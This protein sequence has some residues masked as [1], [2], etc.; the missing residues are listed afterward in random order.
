LAFTTSTDSLIG[1]AGDDIVTASAG[2]VAAA[3]TVIDTSITDSDTLTI[4]HS[5]APGAFTSTNIET[6]DITVNNLGAITVDAANMTGATGGLTVTRGDVVVGG[7]TLTGN[8]A[9]RVDNADSSALG[10]ITA[11][12]ATTTVDINSAAADKAGHVV[13]ANSASGNVSV[14]GAATINASASTGTVSIDAVTNTTAAETGKAS[15]IN[16]A[17]AG[18]VTSH[19]DLTGSVTINAAKATTVTINDAQGGATVNAATTHTADST[20]TVVDVDASGATITVGTGVDDTTTT[21]NI[22]LDVT[23]DGTTATTDAATISGAGHIEL[24]IDGANDGNVDVITLSGN[25][26]SVIYDLA[27]PSSGTAASFTKSGTHSVEIMGDIS[28]FTAI[29]ITD[30]D[31]I[32]IIAGTAAAFNGSNFSGVGKIDLGIDNSNNALTLISGSNLEVTT[33]TQTTGLDIDFSAAGGGDVTITAGDVTTGSTVGTVTVNALNA[34]AAAATTVGTV[35]L[36]AAESNL[37]ATSTVLA[38]KQN[39]VITGDEDV[40][41][42]AVTADSV[43]AANSTGVI[44]MTAAGN[45]D[46]IASGSGNDAITLNDTGSAAATV[47]TG[48]GNDTITITAAA[49]TTTIDGGDGNETFNADEVDQIVMVGGAGNDNFATAVALGG[50]IVGGDGADTITIDGA[51]ALT[52]A[53]TFAFSSIEELDITAANG[54]VDITGAQLAGN[55]T[56]IIDGDAAAD[57]FNVNTG[58][59]AAAAKSADLSN[60]T[61]KS[62]A[63]A[64]I[65]VTGNVGVDTIT[66]GVQSETFTQTISG[67]TI[68]G[69]GG[70]GVDVYQTVTSLSDVLGGATGTSAGTIVNL[71]TTAV[72]ASSIGSNTGTTAYISGNLTSV[73]AGSASFIYT[74]NATTNSGALDTVSGIENVTGSA[75]IDYVVG[76]S[77]NNTIST[78]AGIDYVEGGDGNDTIN[79]GD[80]VDVLAGGNGDD[81]FTITALSDLTDGSNAVEDTIN[82]GN[83]TGDTIAFNGGVTLAAADD[84]TTKVTNVESLSS[85]GAQTGVISLTLHSTFV[86][87]TGITTIDLSGD[88]SATGSNVVDLSNLTTTT[89]MTVTGSA[90]IDTITADSGDITT[91]KGGSGIDVIDL[92]GG[93]TADVLNLV[94]ADTATNNFD[95]VANFAVATD[96]IKVDGTQTTVATAAGAAVVED[97]ATA[98]GNANGATYDLA[99][100]LTL[101][102]NAVDIVTLDS[103]VLANIGNADLDAAGTI[104]DGTQ[105]LASLVTAGA[106]NTAASITVDNAGDKFFILTDDG[107]DSYLYFADSGANTTIVAS[108]IQLVADF[109]GAA[110]DGIAAASLLIA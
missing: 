104:N 26:A 37:T 10:S 91:I 93:T 63:T 38:A 72:N 33:V 57:I 49:A 39:L 83:G 61:I 68:A 17:A 6:I 99:A 2:T 101:S 35:T 46:V 70:T 81:T 103:T 12:T 62:G 25:G 15:V 90:G 22:G 8:K 7:S 13:N 88:T 47:S 106:S 54:Q 92:T 56:L 4:V 73:A 98:A 71:G 45:V 36:H 16:A 42:G 105:L 79:G 32:D 31:V 89:A 55:S 29:T 30:I 27:A 9:V 95:T 60:V 75:G 23:I 102:T 84:F 14:D 96:T 78:A 18:T 65:T 77:G 50:T 20:V 19:A 11:G 53:A 87:D 21:A 34:A 80:G 110:I 48:A 100:A 85:N 74:T 108:E 3:D 64:T 24:D 28:E 5:T 66:G 94:G 82:G 52:M 67:D 109:G 86:T 59:T 44:S 43:S 107:T 1:G 41:L 97:E 51:G 69:G 76:T 58:S 40:T